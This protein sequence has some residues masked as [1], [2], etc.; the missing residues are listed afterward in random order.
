MEIPD[1]MIND[2]IKQSGKGKG[3][4]RS[5]NH[6][7][8]VP[9][10]FR[11]N[12]VP[13]K[14]RSITFA[15]NL[16]PQEDV[17]VE[18]A[19]PMLKTHMLSGDKKLKG[20]AIEDPSVQSLLDLRKG[21]KESRLESLRQ[22]KQAVRGEGSSAIHDKYYEFEYILATN[23]DA[24]RDSSCSDTNEAKDDETDDSNMGLSA[25]EPK[26]DDDAA[27]FR[28]FMY[29]KSTEPLKSTY[30]SPTFTCSYLEYIQSL[31]NETPA[32]ELT[33]LMSNPVYTDAHRFSA[34]P[35]LEGHREEIFPDEAAHHI[36]SPLA[37]TT[38]NP[39][40][41]PQQNFLQAKSKKLM[42]K[43]KKNLRKISFRKAIAQKF[44]EYDQNL[45]AL[46]SIKVSEAI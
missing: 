31:L 21:S 12:V 32:Y 35:N 5:G 16:V 30:P 25:D 1:T 11:K 26:G 2:A 8:N 33:D 20:P 24:T 28:V 17:A 6:E 3:Y 34:V 4:M 29:T 40:T 41:N 39:V 23:S 44:K 10:A 13:R 15:D 14:Q 37:T 18:L 38:H 27:R 9:S 22:E 45:E 43:A 7:V 46:I 42:E 36:S 19:K